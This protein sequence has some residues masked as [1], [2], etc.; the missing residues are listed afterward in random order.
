MD[1][2]NY[3]LDAEK[4]TTSTSTG[5]EERDT[6]RGTV[7][8]KANCGSG[9]LL[10]NKLMPKEGSWR[11]RACTILFVALLAVTNLIVCSVPAMLYLLVP[12]NVHQCSYLI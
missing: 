9:T 5:S 1:S 8:A 7:S 4:G 6:T 3:E 2:P 12:V 10:C 11:K